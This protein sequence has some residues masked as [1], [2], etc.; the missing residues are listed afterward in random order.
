MT[1]IWPVY[2]NR[3]NTSPHC[4]VT[5]TRN[6]SKNIVFSPMFLDF[7]GII[8]LPQSLCQMILLHYYSSNMCV[9][10]FF[11]IRPLEESLHKKWSTLRG[12]LDSSTPRVPGVFWVDFLM[13]SRFQYHPVEG[14]FVLCSSIA[15][16]DKGAKACEKV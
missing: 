9:I 10:F 3:A 13:T 2:H 1:R 11:E 12:E 6:T 8:L 16:L 4:I 5:S 14:P 7:L 15:W